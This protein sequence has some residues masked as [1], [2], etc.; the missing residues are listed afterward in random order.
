M[1][2]LQ[3]A[4]FDCLVADDTLSAAALAQ[5]RTDVA[6]WTDEHAY[7]LLPYSFC[8]LES[9]TIEQVGGLPGS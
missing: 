1:C 2:T 7:A 3:R 5:A 9:L 6:V 4:P 8:V